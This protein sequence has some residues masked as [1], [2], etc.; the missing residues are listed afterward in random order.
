[1]AFISRRF[2]RRNRGES[3]RAF[4]FLRSQHMC[5]AACLS[6]IRAGGFSSRCF[7]LT[8][9][10]A[11]PE[12]ERAQLHRA[13]GGGP[14]IEQRAK[15]P[16]AHRQ[17]ESKLAACKGTNGAGREGRTF[18]NSHHAVCS[19]LTPSHIHHTTPAEA[20]HPRK[21]LGRRI[22]EPAT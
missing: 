14:A 12:V 3:A 19:L 15:L 13:S 21:R 17:T 1:M 7:S 5:S 4:L 18:K 9:L 22:R 8:L 20:A 6:T 11:N 16:S 10:R 2:T